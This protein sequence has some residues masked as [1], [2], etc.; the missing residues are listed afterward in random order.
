MKQTL[1]PITLSGSYGEGGG[2]L[3]RT[4]VAMSA[5]IQQPVRIHSIRSALRKPGLTS[6]D[7]TFLQIIS[8]AVEA[9]VEGDKLDSD[10]LIF[11]PTRVPRAVRGEFDVRCHE[12]GLVPGNAQVILGSA[13][14]V[15]ARAGSMS[16]VSVRGETHN[17]NTVGYDSFER[18]T[19]VAYQQLGLCAYPSL[20]STGFGQSGY[21]QVSL[22]VE[23]SAMEAV[24]WK[25]R[26]LL[27]Q[28][29]GTVTSTDM[30]P[31][32][33]ERTKVMLERLWLDH[34][35]TGEVET[36]EV[37]GPE[38]GISITIGA[39]FERGF[40]QGSAV[41]PRGG[42][43]TNSINRAWRTFADWY[44]SDATV[45]MFLADQ[46]LIPAAFA[47]GRTVFQTP[48]VTRRLVTMAWVIK[49]FL[50]IKITILGRDGEPGTVTIER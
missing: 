41:V 15:L 28:I 5:L 29:W 25:D 14:P 32:A 44:K 10:Q 16:L 39:N 38:P 7:L 27:K 2:A 24:H 4:A 8:Q 19:L 43:L 50:P 18:S 45:D 22:E 20:V 34:R 23:P 33:V 47:D 11:C 31:E 46:M 1:E 42:T 12:Q 13:L 9:N 17:N 49:Q 48:Q 30:A 6:E 37:S 35:L 26:G 21:G 3:F 36:R 40:G